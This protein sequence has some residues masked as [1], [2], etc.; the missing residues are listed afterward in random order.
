[1]HCF[2]Q[3]K[4]ADARADANADLLEG[5]FLEID[6]R[7]FQ[8]LDAGDKSVMYERIKSPGFFR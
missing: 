6:A 4:P 1:V 8:R 3:R 5:F 7:V 2:D